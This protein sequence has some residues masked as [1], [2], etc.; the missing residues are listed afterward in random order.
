MELAAAAGLDFSAA[1]H[2]PQKLELGGFSELHFAQTS[3]S[4]FPQRA[5]KLLA[6]EFS[7]PH[8]EQRIGDLAGAGR[9]ASIA[10]T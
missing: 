6:A 10:R 9:C 5:Q 8:F 3:V 4:A 7:F 1:P 2:L